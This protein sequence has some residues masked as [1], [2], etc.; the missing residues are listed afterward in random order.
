[1]YLFN[2][3]PMYL[4]QYQPPKEAT[5]ANSQEALALSPED[6]D[7]NTDLAKP[8]RALPVGRSSDSPGS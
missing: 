6:T 4:Q 1:M 3:L 2:T 5:A 8:L 7:E